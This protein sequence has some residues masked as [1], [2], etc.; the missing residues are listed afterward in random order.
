M[1]IGENIFLEVACSQHREQGELVSGDVFLHRRTQNRLSLV[2]CDGAGSGMRAN[3]VASVIASMAVNQ[4]SVKGSLLRSVKMLIETFA[5]GERSADVRQAAFT[6]VNIDREGHVVVVEFA[7]PHTLFFRGDQPLAIPQK[8][9]RVK[10][11]SGVD[12]E[13][14]FYQFKATAEDRLLLITDGITESGYAT[15][16]LPFGWSREGVEELVLR[17]IAEHPTLSADALS[18]EVTDAAKTNDLF[19]PKNDMSCVA[20][21]FRRPRKILVCSGPPFDKEKD[22][23]LAGRVAEY[24][25]EVII[26]GGTTAQII[27]REL[28]REIVVQLKRDPS[29]LPSASTMEGVSFITEGVLTLGR[30]KVLLE[31]MRSSDLPGSGIDVR[32]VRMLL[33]HDIVEFIVGTRINA[34]HQDPDIPV[35]LELRRNVIKDIARILNEKFMKEVSI[36]YI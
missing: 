22:S 3:V 13:F 27:A 28:N 30:V 10:T 25:G 18:R 1:V 24:D 14:H 29:G 9:H 15:R 5:R 2:L 35:E 20:L 32:L 17:R 31:S 19:Y 4:D 7:S 23:A 33:T 26:S 36:L 8:H 34:L 6:I 12:A 11:S 21:Y 16:R